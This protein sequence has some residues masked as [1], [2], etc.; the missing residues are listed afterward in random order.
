MQTEEASPFFDAVERLTSQQDQQTLVDCLLNII[1]RLADTPHVHLYGLEFKRGKRVCGSIREAS[2]SDSCARDVLDE[3]NSFPIE[4]DSNLKQSLIFGGEYFCH[5]QEGKISELTIP[6]KGFYGI[7]QALI[8]NETSLSRS[9][10]EFLIRLMAIYSNQFALLR[11][12]ELDPLTGLLNRDAFNRRMAQFTKTNKSDQPSGKEQCFALFDIDHFKSIN[13]QFGHVYGD[14]V[15]LLV[16]RIAESCFRYEDLKFRYGG[17]EIALL[18]KANLTDSMS[19]LER[20]RRAVEN[21]RFPQQEKITVSTG[22]TLITPQ[23]NLSLL[24]DK[25][26]TAL[27]FAKNNGRNQAHAYEALL[28]KNQVEEIKTMK[29]NVELY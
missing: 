11:R 9:T 14:E 28:S 29:E 8:L 13:D 24:I 18:L 6:V 22:T 26:D 20:F 12:T 25:A 4:K 23:T 1:H 17:E 3:K 21:Y 16:A 19:A 2:F 10:A 27:Y 7:E 15:L 5:N